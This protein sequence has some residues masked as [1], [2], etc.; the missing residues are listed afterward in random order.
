MFNVKISLFAR[1]R[2][3]EHNIDSLHDKIIEMTMVF[4]EAVDIYLQ[5][6]RS[7]KYRQTS[8]KI[9]IIEHDSDTLRREIESKLYEQNLIPDLR[10]NI[11][12]LVEN[13][14][15]VVNLFDEV[16]HKFYIERPDIPEEYHNKLKE[17]VN[18][19]ADCAENMAIASRAFFR[20]LVTLR[21]YSKKVYL[22]E[23]QSDKTAA[24]LR[25]DV[26]DSNLDLAH[27]MQ[28]NNFIEEV[29]NK[30]GGPST[31]FFA[32]NDVAFIEHRE[33]LTQQLRE[34][35]KLQI[36]NEFAPVSYAKITLRQSALAK[37]HCPT[38]AIFKPDITPIVGAGELGELYVE[39]TPES[40]ERVSCKMDKAETTTNK[41]NIDGKDI[42]YPS[43]I[44]SEIG[45]IDHISQHTKSD[46][47]KF[48]IKEAIEWLSDSRSGGAYIVELFEDPPA[49]KDW[50][51]LSI[52]KRQLF[53]TFINGLENFGS[54]LYALKIKQDKGAAVLYGIK[55]EEAKDKILEE[56]EKELL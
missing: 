10:G 23:H 21:D 12:E 19:V 52:Q 28:I 7:E 11:L 17:L 5:E 51:T 9:K 29:E 22:L 50:D 25:N 4:K 38:H 53:S 8:K 45:A 3:L 31:D 46:K 40:I 15:R 33:L 14:D 49:K 32:D 24:K 48:S 35:K 47:R 56:I 13:L 34:I 54:G 55:L 41:K 44:R 37:S 1:T 42:P 27:K 30:G 2:D 39:L 20:D 36:D 16:A 6:Q 43:R 18:Q 26:F